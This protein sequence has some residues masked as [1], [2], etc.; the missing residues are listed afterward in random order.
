MGGG[1]CLVG[2]VALEQL[3]ILKTPVIPVCNNE[4]LQE[5]LERETDL[6]AQNQKLSERPESC[7]ELICEEEEII[8]EFTEDL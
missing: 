6:T 1:A 7:P 5:C 3:G 4:A 2:R 8:E